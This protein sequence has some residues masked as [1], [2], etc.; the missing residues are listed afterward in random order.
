MPLPDW[1]E[2]SERRTIVVVQIEDRVGL[3]EV[4]EIAAVD[5]VD[6][7]SLATGSMPSAMVPGPAAYFNFLT[8]GKVV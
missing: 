8:T 3:S 7:I 4:E 6:G 2:L 1:V 5:G